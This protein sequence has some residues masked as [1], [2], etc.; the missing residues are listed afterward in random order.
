MIAFPDVRA[1]ELGF[2]P[3]AAAILSLG[4]Q[5]TLVLRQGLSGHNVLLVVSTCFGCDLS[6]LLFAT[7][8][9][10]AVVTAFPMCSLMLRCSGM[11]YLTLMSARS[12]ARAMHEE[13]AGLSDTCSCTQRVVLAAL[14]VSL[15]NP[16]AWIE[17]VLIIGAVSSIVE[18][19]SVIVFAIGAALGSLCKFSVL[20]F[21][22]RMLS[23]LFRWPQF[24]RI[25]DTLS[26]I[27]MAAMALLI[28]IELVT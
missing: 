25:F 10:D 18:P 28:L 6:L 11:A 7:T 16:L 3:A 20:G 14:V 15:L 12:F 17:S 5:N 2:T 21:G 9:L 27:A 1:F 26:G 23:P 8:G 13:H 4:P 24:R 22:A 19:N